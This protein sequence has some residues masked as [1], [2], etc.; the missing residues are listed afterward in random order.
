ME[1][2]KGLLDM[3]FDP[4]LKLLNRR[5]KQK[6]MKGPAVKKAFADY[7]KQ[8]KKTQEVIDK[9]LEDLELERDKH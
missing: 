4:I 6:V 8:H 7:W 3:F 9:A 5:R 2:S 1:K